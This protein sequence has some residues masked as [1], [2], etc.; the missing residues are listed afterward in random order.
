M[1]AFKILIIVLFWIA[2]TSYKKPEKYTC[3]YYSDK[4]I[5]LHPVNNDFDFNKIEKK[6]ENKLKL[7]SINK[8]NIEKY[9]EFERS[10]DNGT[11]KKEFKS[12]KAVKKSILT[13]LND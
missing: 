13:A 11:Y 4:V 5:I 8:S 6:F 7:D 12:K 10:V 2:S 9:I 3:F 1:K